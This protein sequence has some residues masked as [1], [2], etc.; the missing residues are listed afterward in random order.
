MQLK[1]ISATT[2][3]KKKKNQTPGAAAPTVE[4]SLQ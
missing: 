4:V 1:E 3:Q 2:F